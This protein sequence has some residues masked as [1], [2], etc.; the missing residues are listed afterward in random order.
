MSTT[1]QPT[2]TPVPSP[3]PQPKK[4]KGKPNAFAD[5]LRKWD[6]LLNA[7]ADHAAELAPIEAHRAALADSLDKAR[8]AKGL[9]E[10]HLATKQVMTQ[11]L[12]EIFTEGKD[13]ATRLRGA[14]R[15]ELGLTTEQLVQF[16]IHPV[17]RRPSRHK[18]AAAP[19]PAPQVEV[20]ATKAI[21]GT[22]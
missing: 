18:P 20:S 6:S 16:G 21:Q 12:S 19:A 14:I 4:K 17:R 3:T 11:N 13:R 10:S 8:Q 7:V 9:Q 2:P 1:A 15:A 22:E 5:H